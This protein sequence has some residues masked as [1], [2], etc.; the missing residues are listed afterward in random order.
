[1]KFVANMAILCTLLNFPRKLIWNFLQTF[2]LFSRCWSVFLFFFCT[3]KWLFG[4]SVQVH[5]KKWTFK[6][7]LEIFLKSTGFKNKHRGRTGSTWG[8]TTCS[9]GQTGSRASRPGTCECPQILAKRSVNTQADISMMTF[10][11]NWG[12][13]PT[14]PLKFDSQTIL[15][16]WAIWK[17][18]VT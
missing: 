1:M 9:L 8:K 5:K 18:G 12:F 16:M 10:L 13:P 14:C 4:I 7:C 6:L 11:A 17:E 3:S 15:I 2:L